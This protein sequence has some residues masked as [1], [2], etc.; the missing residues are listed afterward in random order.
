MSI[1]FG[2]L[3]E[4]IPFSL[5]DISICSDSKGCHS[6]KKSQHMWTH[7]CVSF[8]WFW[9]GVNAID[10]FHEDSLFIASIGWIFHIGKFRR[11]KL[12]SYKAWFNIRPINRHWEYNSTSTM[13]KK[14]TESSLSQ[15]EIIAAILAALR[16]LDLS[17]FL[18]PELLS[19][20][21]KCIFCYW[22]FFSETETLQKR[23]W[24]GQS[25]GRWRKSVRGAFLCA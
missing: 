10:G 19:Q 18:S 5:K 9:A 21:G 11:C 23:E 4:T 13:D 3:T 14:N 15:A 17:I 2:N 12:W 7:N 16:A 24:W 6:R 8:F 22:E 20:N 25:R 1:L